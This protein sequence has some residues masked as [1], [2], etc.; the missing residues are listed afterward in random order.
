MKKR[1]NIHNVLQSEVVVLG[2][3]EVPQI[4]DQ[5]DLVAN[6]L[7]KTPSPVLRDVAFTA[8]LASR[9]ALAKAAI[10]ATSPADLREKLD[11]LKRRIESGKITSFYT[12]GVY[13]GTERC[14][15]PG[16]TVFLFPGEGSQYPDMLRDLSLHFPACRSAFDDADTASAMAGAPMAPSQWIFPSGEASAQSIAES[17]GMAAAVQSVVAADTGLL[18]L[19][20]QV[21]I[22]PDA[23]AGVGVGE[24]VAMEAARAIAYPDRAARLRGLSAGHKLLMALPAAEGGVLPRCLCFSVSGLPRQRLDAILSTCHGDALVTRDQASDLFSVCARAEAADT[25]VARLEAAGGSTHRLPINKPFHTP[26]IKPVLPALASYFGDIITA[27]PEVPV[28]SFMTAAPIEGAPETWGAQAAEQWANPTRIRDTIER[29]YADGFRV[30]VELGARGSLSS[31]VAATLRHRPH[32]ALAANSSHRSDILQ[33]HHTLAA[34]VAHGAALDVE[35]LHALRGSA[36]VDFAHPGPT[37]AQR[38]QHAVSLN[39]RF[40]TLRNAPLPDGLVARTPHAERQ[41]A[42]VATTDAQADG[43]A[44]FPMIGDAEIIR[45]TPGENIDL[46]KKL[47]VFDHPFLVD[48]TLCPGGTSK[49]D[50]DRHGLALLPVE[51]L[52]ETMAEA[53]RRLFP[54]RVVIAV[55]DLAS[56]GWPRLEN[57]SRAIRIQARHLPRIATDGERVQA[58][59]FDSASFSGE[60]PLRLASATLVVAD[61]YPVPPEPAADALTTPAHLDWQGADLYPERLGYG[62]AFQSLQEVS[63]RGENGLHAAAVALPRASLFRSI[64]DPRFSLDPVF[65]SSIGAA[66]A[67]WHAVEPA[68]GR[69]HFPCGCDRIDFYAPVPAEWAKCALNLFVDPSRDK[70]DAVCADAE[71]IGDERRLLLR[72]TGWRNRVIAVRPSLHHLI[73][74]PSDGFFTSETPRG[75]MPALP[76]EVI[77]CVAPAVPPKEL[78]AADF[79]IRMELTA[80][81]TLAASEHVKWA[82]LAGSNL[83][84]VEWLFG[85]IAAKDAV[86]RCLLARYSRKWPAADIRIESDEQGK[87]HPQ[88]EWRRHCGAPMDISITHTSDQIIA[89]VAPNARIGI[90]VEKRDRVLSEEFIA[91]AFSPLEQE[92]AAESGDG[93]TTLLRFWCA[94]EAFSKALGSGLRYGTGDLCARTVDT[95]TGR[96]EM[97]ATRLWLQPFPNLRGKRIDVQTCIIDNTVLAVCVLDGAVASPNAE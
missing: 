61:G 47:S 90:D 75:V 56:E 57:G 17:L 81:V 6:Y 44:S 64:P 65:L 19:F 97:E 8:G 32:L 92:V 28:Y 12:K 33:L 55:E 84:R 69:L 91:A 27:P 71:I 36:T 49:T 40:A 46:L 73:L 25:L 3:D 10:V 4:V 52:L 24:L 18:R 82:E 13:I 93:A 42:A 50:R 86:R 5:I 30:F 83:R 43:L 72:A 14:P 15:A 2:A 29:L 34:L 87:P 74:H 11:L 58:E 22:T 1:I 78:A 68:N 80:S 48:R 79:D 88:G 16:R 41:A 96:I 37:H 31:C 60:T 21:G 51:V 53:A 59:I 66:L 9:D 63:L 38:I 35:K 26:W 67:A 39:T 54:K 45:F 7:D 77:C 85:R 89:A 62:P 23:V 20:L 76:Q 94:K 70:A 95:A